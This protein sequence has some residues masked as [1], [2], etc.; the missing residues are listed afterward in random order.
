MMAVIVEICKKFVLTI[1]EKKTKN[2]CMP[3]QGEKPRK[4]SKNIPRPATSFTLGVASSRG[5]TSP[6]RVADAAG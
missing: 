2:I 3:T 5:R 4:Q 6:S 1:L